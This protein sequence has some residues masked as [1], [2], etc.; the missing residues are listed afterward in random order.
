MPKKLTDREK[1]DLTNSM[2]AAR[3]KAEDYGVIEKA[4]RIFE[5][6]QSRFPRLTGTPDFK[7]KREAA[8]A[9]AN[10]YEQ[11]AENLDVRRRPDSIQQ[12]RHEKEAGDPNALRLSFEEWKKL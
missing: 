10:M 8:T 1:N 11:E 5:N 3:K 2:D 7:S 4:T 12:Y 9:L 6:N